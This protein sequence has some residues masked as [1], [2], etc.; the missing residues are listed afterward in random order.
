MNEITKLY[1][2]REFANLSIYI[3]II[4]F[5]LYSRC[6]VIVVVDE[7]GHFSKGNS[8]YIYWLHIYP[9]D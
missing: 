5:L 3:Y 6:I 8:S 4:T 9:Q 2:L 1:N 7:L